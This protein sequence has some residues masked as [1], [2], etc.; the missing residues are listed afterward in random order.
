MPAKSGTRRNALDLPLEEQA[1]RLGETPI[2]QWQR[3]LVLD[4]LAELENIP[5]DERAVPW[6]EVRRRLLADRK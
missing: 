4:R 2:P 6:E 5:P 1:E 3:E